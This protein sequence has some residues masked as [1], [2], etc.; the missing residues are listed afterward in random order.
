VKVIV[1]T[2]FKGR[3]RSRKV[4]TMTNVLEVCAP[5]MQF[6]YLLPGWEGSSH[7]GH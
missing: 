7:D 6:I 1:P 2:R 3:Y 4:Y 5:D